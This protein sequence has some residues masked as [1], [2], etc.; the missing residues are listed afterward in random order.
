MPSKTSLED[1]DTPSTAAANP[2]PPPSTGVQT[3]SKGP[4]FTLVP[5][6]QDMARPHVPPPPPAPDESDDLSVDDGSPPLLSEP[7]V[8]EFTAVQAG[9]KKRVTPLQHAFPTQTEHS[10]TRTGNSFGALDVDDVSDEKAADSDGA[11]YKAVIASSL[12]VGR[13]LRR[14]DQKLDATVPTWM[15]TFM[16][17]MDN[18]FAELTSSIKTGEQRH[19]DSLSHLEARL[20]AKFDT[21]NGQIGDL[22]MDAIDHERRINDQVQRIDE[23]KSNL[24]KLESVHKGYKD[25]NNDLVATLRTDVNDTRAKIPELRRAYQDS[26]ADLTTA[27]NDVATLVDDLRHHHQEPIATPPPATPARGASVD[28]PPTPG[29]N[30]FNLPGGVTP[31]Y[32]GAAS[33]PSGNCRTRATPAPPDP[34]ARQPN[35]FVDGPSSPA[36]PSPVPQGALR[37]DPSSVD[38]ASLI[39]GCPPPDIPHVTFNTPGRA[40]TDAVVS[41][42]LIVGGP[43]TSPRPSDKERLARSRGVGLFDIAGLAT[44]K[45][46]G[47]TQGVQALTVTFIHNCGYQSF[48]NTISPE[49]ILLCLSEIQQLHRKVVQ[50]WYNTR[51][52]L[53]GPS[54]ERILD[55]GLKAFPILRTMDVHDAIEFYDKFQG[56]SHDYLIPLMPF[57]AIRLGNNFEG[58][59]VPGLGTQRYHECASAL[60]ELLP[61][62]LP[63]SNAEIQS[64]LASV[65][66]ES[67]NG[68]DLL[69]RVLELTVPVFDPTVP[70]QQPT[71]D[72]DGTMG[73]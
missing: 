51:T 42:V 4:P 31:T 19:A 6:P 36:T 43:I 10:P 72:S 65:R 64:K 28:P 40:G 44:E 39:G 8:V 46:H 24:L 69:W 53:S 7:T 45:Y 67:K 52:Q 20:L 35:H 21:F 59:F 15:D 2:T 47:G 27:I 41:D 55:R 38:L 37:R 14:Q 17:T 50:S 29:L 18:R 63:T 58:L 54:L 66:V 70:I 25:T 23:L 60:F 71:Y 33:F 73:R 68:Y 3:R 57:D 62:L 11:L 16:K 12:A 26:A 9:G 32:R 22:R 56:L 30:R 48:S 49:D 61:R 13:I 1:D 34:G 5:V